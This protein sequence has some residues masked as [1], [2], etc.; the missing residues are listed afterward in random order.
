MLSP[1]SMVKKI[2]STRETLRGM[3]WRTKLVEEVNERRGLYALLS[4]ESKQRGP[5]RNHASKISFARLRNSLTLRKHAC[6]ISFVQLRISLHIRCEQSR[7][8]C[9]GQAGQE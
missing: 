5:V 8:D 1:L 6:K 9:L 2:P 7:R 4:P 3:M